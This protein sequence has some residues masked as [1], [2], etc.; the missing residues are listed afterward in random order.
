MVVWL[1]MMGRELSW[2]RVFFDPVAIGSDGPAF[3]SIHEIWYGSFVYPILTV[4]VFCTLIGLW[5]NFEWEH[6]K[7]KLCISMIDGSLLIAAAIASQLVFERNVILLLQPY[8]QLLE[9]LSELI[10]Y[11]CMISILVTNGFRRK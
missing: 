2:G 10:V 11:W 6:M 7:S 9:E 8:S 5:R 4:I 3:P 1:I